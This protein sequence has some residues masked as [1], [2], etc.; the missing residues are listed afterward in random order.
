[1][2]WVTYGVRGEEHLRRV[3]P[4][5]AW[6]VVLAGVWQCI[7]QGATML[8]HQKLT[9]NFAGTRPAMRIMM[10]SFLPT[11]I[12]LSVFQLNTYLDS[13]I[14]QLLS[15]PRPDQVQLHLPGWVAEAARWAGVH[16][17]LA[18]G[19]VNY[20]C[21]QGNVAA[22]LRSMLLYQFPLGV[23]GIAI[24]TAI[25]PALARAATERAKDGGRHFAQTLRHGLRL[26]FF[27]GLPASVG[28]FMTRVPMCRAMFEG[29]ELT[30]ADALLDARILAGFAPAIWAYSMTHVL[31][32]GFYA[33][34]DTRTPMRL[35]LGM[36]ALNVTL[37]LTLVWF[38]GVQAL[39]LSTALCAIIQCLVLLRLIRRHVEK[40][41]DQ[42]VMA[43]W[44][45][46]LGL[47]ILMAAAI[48]P[49]GH[50]WQPP[51]WRGTV[52]MLAVMVSV[53][54]GVYMGAAALLGCEELTWLRKRRAE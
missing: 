45:R 39:A 8:R 40:P 36:V 43:S 17:H 28:V 12:P 9:L 37:N 44:G 38:L 23:F 16:G 4:W 2:L 18:E 50:Y 51:S 11:L 48:W 52:L 6:S 34:K 25:F 54:A 30:I 21:A 22:F 29:K 13:T 47:S 31:L 49:I 24:A 27:I 46:T 1:M 41:V 3:V 53:G 26:T 15:P 33:L 5:V 10:G 42:N 14:A 32:R 7:S 20:P 19:F 35:S